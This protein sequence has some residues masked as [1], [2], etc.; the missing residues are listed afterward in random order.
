MRFLC[1]IFPICTRVGAILAHGI[2]VV[3]LVLSLFIP[4]AEAEFLPQAGAAPLSVWF[5]RPA[6]DWEKEGLPI[7]NGA[8]GAVIAGGVD[9]DLIQFNEKTL[10][11]GGPGA[12]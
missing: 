5:D 8:M 11:T 3:P 12:E 7:G 2:Y 9:Q 1:S 10:W 6:G 4:S